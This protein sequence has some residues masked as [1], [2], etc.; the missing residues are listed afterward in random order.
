M[1]SIVIYNEVLNIESKKIKIHENIK[2][3]NI[4]V[5]DIEFYR[6]YYV[7]FWLCHLSNFS[8]KSV[9]YFISYSFQFFK[10]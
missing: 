9:E 4:Y 6:E 8:S 7:L 3:F 1:T 10:K 5:Y 2:M